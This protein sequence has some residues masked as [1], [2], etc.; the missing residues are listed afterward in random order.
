MNLAKKK[1]KLGA[2]DEVDPELN[3]KFPCYGFQCGISE[4]PRISFGHISKYLIEEVEIRKKLST[5]KLIVKGYNFYKS[6]HVRQIFSKRES[7]KC[8]IKSQ[9]LPSMK[10]G[11]V[12]TVIVVLHSNGDIAKAVCGCPAGVDGRCNQLAAIMFAMEDQ[13]KTNGT[14][15]HAVRQGMVELKHQLMYHAHHSHT[16]GMYPE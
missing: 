14:L 7:D 8:F 16:H 13:W 4:L 10:K 11:K 1:K 5:E 15:K 2:A 12:H 3:E 6:G 9:V